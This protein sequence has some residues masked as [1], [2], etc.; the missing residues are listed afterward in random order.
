V[1]Y[2][3]VS[4]KKH[5]ITSLLGQMCPPAAASAALRKLRLIVPSHVGWVIGTFSCPCLAVVQPHSVMVDGAARLGQQHGTGVK[6]TWYWWQGWG[7]WGKCAF[8]RFCSFAGQGTEATAMAAVIVREVGV[9]DGAVVP[10]IG[11][12]LWQDAIH[13]MAVDMWGQ[14]PMTPMPHSQAVEAEPLCCS[15]RTHHVV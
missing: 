7:L 1:S 3:T 14:A 2:G 10:I 4:R 9:I 6:G 13:V 15:V 8:G 11:V 12:P 5:D